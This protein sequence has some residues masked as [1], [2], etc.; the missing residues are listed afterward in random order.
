MAN[1]ITIKC[2]ECGTEIPPDKAKLPC[3]K[4]GGTR[5]DYSATFSSHLGLGLAKYNSAR[6][7]VYGIIIALI[8]LV[9]LAGYIVSTFILPQL[10]DLIY[11]IFM[12][13]CTVFLFIALGFAIWRD[14]ILEDKALAFDFKSLNDWLAILRMPAI[15]IL[16]PLIVLYVLTHAYMKTKMP[17]N[18]DF[19]VLSTALGGLVLAAG[20]FAV[21]DNPNKPQLI[22]IAKYFIFAVVLFIL[23]TLTIMVIT[24]LNF[25]PN[26]P[27]LT[28]KWIITEIIFVLFGMGGIFGGSFLFSMAIIDLVISLRNF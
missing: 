4:C 12:G 16:F 21:K 18:I 5:R 26:V 9:A 25:N 15:L 24:L 8:I 28:Y 27:E 19:I 3:P 11:W 14:K 13:L 6:N 23:F 2:Q 22:K 10:K 7:W 1:N 17:F 20:E